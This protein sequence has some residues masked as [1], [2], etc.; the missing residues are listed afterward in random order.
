M[1]STTPVSRI[2]N[3]RYTI[4]TILITAIILDGILLWSKLVSLFTAVQLVVLILEGIGW[5][6]VLWL[7]NPPVQATPLNFSQFAGRFPNGSMENLILRVLAYARDEQDLALNAQEISAELKTRYQIP[8][9]PTIV[10]GLLAEME[11]GYPD[12]IEIVEDGHWQVSTEALK[13]MR[14]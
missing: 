8:R 9:T 1:P 2:A 13:L 4:G 12:V 10:A 14:Q 3:I 7:L 11:R 5:F 6:C